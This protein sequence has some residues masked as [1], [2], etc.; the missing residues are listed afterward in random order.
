ML[1]YLLRQEDTFT[2]AEWVKQIKPKKIRSNVLL[3]DKWVFEWEPDN[4][5]FKD[6]GGYGPCVGVVIK[7]HGGEVTVKWCDGEITPISRQN[8]RLAPHPK[9]R[10]TSCTI[11]KYTATGVILKKLDNKKRR[12]IDNKSPASRKQ[13]PP[14]RPATRKQNKH[15][16]P[17]RSKAPKRPPPGTSP[18][19]RP[20]TDHP[21]TVNYNIRHL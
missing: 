6:T 7:P 21:A 17:V 12:A 2:T 1:D 13:Q 10:W 9:S 3:A 19:M 20:L 18:P 14:K 8:I 11:Q 15:K 4:P 16:S 5:N